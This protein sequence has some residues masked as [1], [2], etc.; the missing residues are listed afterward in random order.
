MLLTCYPGLVAI[1]GCFMRI[2]LDAM[3]SDNYPFPEVEGAVLA[4]KEFS[5]IS[6]F[7]VGDQVRVAPEL[8]RYNT[9]GL[10]LQIIHASQAV[11]MTDKPGTIGKAKPDSSMHVGMALVAEGNADA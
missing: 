10:D 11:S 3:G 7:L 2:A 9:V 1:G 5:D 8:A 6:I 4:L